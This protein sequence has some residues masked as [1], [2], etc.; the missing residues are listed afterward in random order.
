MTPKISVIIPAY[1]CEATVEQSVRSAL[2]QTFSDIEVLVADDGS[3]DGTPEIL[4]RL[5]EEDARIRVLTLPE[6]GGVANARNRAAGCARAEWI[7]FL[8][9][10]DMWTPDKLAVETELA[11]RT[12]AD[13]VYTAAA[14]IDADG[15]PTGREFRVPETVTCRSMLNGN[16][17]ICSSVLLKKELFLRHPMERSDLHE[18]Y[19]CWMAILKD[20]AKTA[21]VTEPKV[22]YRITKGSKSGNKRRSAAMAWKTYRHLGFG[23]L[24]SLRYFLGYCV[25]GVKR[26]WL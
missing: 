22:L 15:R 23:R 20:G 24:K 16:D 6:N 11:A 19:L 25:H 5:S 18:D 9:S 2:A 10:D 12:G 21:G 4:K 1:R 8:D 26:Y 17:L 3:D 14:C 13:L 7:A